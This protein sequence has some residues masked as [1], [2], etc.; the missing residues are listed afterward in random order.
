MRVANLCVE[1]LNHP[2][3]RFEEVCSNLKGYYTV[4]SKLDIKNAYFQIQLSEASREITTFSTL[5]RLFRYKRIFCGINCAP[6]AFQKI[7]ELTTKDCERLEVCIFDF[8]IHGATREIDDKRLRHFLKK[9]KQLGLT[10]N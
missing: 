6:E 9:F 10:L 2:I 7:M 3:P 4:F 1:R 5:K 8:L